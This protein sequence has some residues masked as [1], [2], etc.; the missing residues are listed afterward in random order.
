[1]VAEEAPLTNVPAREGGLLA[2]G[3]VPHGRRGQPPGLLHHVDHLS[4]Q[5]VPLRPLII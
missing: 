3:V 4:N 2:G 5:P 1:M